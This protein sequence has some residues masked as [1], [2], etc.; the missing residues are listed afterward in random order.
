MSHRRKALSVPRL[1]GVLAL[2]SARYV[3]AFLTLLFVAFVFYV[4]NRTRIH[5]K[6]S[7][8]LKPNLII[9]SNHQSLIDSFLI[10]LALCVPQFLVMPWLLPWH[11]PEKELLWYA[12][13]EVRYAVVESDSG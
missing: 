5:G 11:L 8:R 6:A 1:A 12:A 2:G 4:L 10:G 9:V 13:P 3:V 7:F